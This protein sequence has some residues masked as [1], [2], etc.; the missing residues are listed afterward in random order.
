MVSLTSTPETRRSRLSWEGTVFAAVF[1]ALGTRGLIFGDFAGPWQRIPLDAM[2]GRPIIALVCAVFELAGGLALL[3]RRLSR[4]AALSLLIYTALWAV[5]LKLPAV[6]YFPAMEA[7]WLGLGEI[8]VI[9]AGAWAIY[10]LKDAHKV[11]QIGPAARAS[12]S[13]RGARMLFALSLPAI[14]LSHLFYPVQTVEFIPTWVPWP[15]AWAY[16][17]GIASLTA[18]AAI[19]TG[20]MA[21]TAAQL[22]ATML[23]VITVIVWGPGL[24]QSPGNHAWTAFIMSTAIASGAF[25]VAGTYRRRPSEKAITVSHLEPGD[26]R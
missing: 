11:L 20:L 21:R 10:A 5:L 15:Y 12:A 3:H 24:I 22:E 16:L 18:S 13:V 1:I 26:S 6:I 19:L 23:A 17:T 4:P 14:G 9:A 25:A 8:T 7:T 2:P